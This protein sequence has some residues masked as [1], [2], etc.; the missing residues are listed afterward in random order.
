MTYFGIVFTFAFATGAARVLLVAPQ[1]GNTAALLL[2]VPML[3]TVSW[4]VARR[5]LRNRGLRPG[6]CVA[7]G[8]LAFLLL[9]GS[10]AI[11]ASILRGQSAVEWARTIANP[12]GFLGLAGQL[13]FAAM[14]FLVGRF[15]TL[16][17]G[18]VTS[19]TVAK[20]NDRLRSQ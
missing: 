11:L 19:T 16:S 14:P 13:V 6:E 10:E 1:V 4:V 9:M 5:L 3:I 8:L 20:A 7:M 15:G 17:K 12:L 18:T 2:E